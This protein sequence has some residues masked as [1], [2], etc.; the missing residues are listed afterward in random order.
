MT[1]KRLVILFCGLLLVASTYAQ[2]NTPTVTK[3]PQAVAL[4]SQS[5]SAA[6]G[7]SAINSIQD[8]TGTGSITYNWASE[9]VQVPVMVRGMGASNFR[10]DASLSNGTR[11]WAVSGYAAILITPDGNRTSLGS[12]NLMTAGSMTVPYI[13]IAA[14]L[15]DMT[16]SISYVG[17]ATFNGGQA[18]QV[19]F[20]PNN[21]NFAGISSLA[22]L[23]TFDLYIDPTSSL[24]IGLTE[25]GHSDN[26]FTITYTHEIDFSNYQQSGNIAAP[27]TITEK[28]G[29]Q[30]TWSIVLSSISFNN[31]LAESIF[32]P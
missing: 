25:T 18:I 27:Y 32:T 11:T 28:I 3:D 14:I 7:S 8:Y 30:T 12:Y 29:G 5:L 9:P 22:A 10:L 13:R 20:V 15:G 16:T 31:G 26:N 17:P 24:V 23:G 19:H 4:L 21:P 2:G 6:G 1:L